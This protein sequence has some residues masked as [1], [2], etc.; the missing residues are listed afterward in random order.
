[1]ESLD[2]DA[3]TL[4]APADR[5]EGGQAQPGH[6]LRR[7]GDRH[8]DGG[9]DDP[10]RGQLPFDRGR[11]YASLRPRLAARARQPGGDCHCGGS[12]LILK[13]AGSV[14]SEARI[15]PPLFPNLNHLEVFREKAISFRPRR[16]ALW[17]R[18]S[19]FRTC[20]RRCR[21]PPCPPWA[22]QRPPSRFPRRTARR[23]RSKS[24]RGKWVVLYFYPKDMTSG[25]TIEA[26][27]FQDEPAPVRGQECGDSGRERGHR[28]QPQAVL[29]QGRAD[30]P[31]A[32]DP[33][34]K[35][36]SA[37]GS[38]GGYNGMTIANRNTFLIDPQGQDRQ[39]VDQGE[40]GD[41]ASDVLAV[42]PDKGNSIK[43][44]Q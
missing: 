8:G 7:A 38:L 44:A 40:P 24:F 35:V 6:A 27:N 21:R 1:M 15:P 41:R 39:G 9:D 19:L 28:R 17:P 16:S 3:S 23:F 5:G 29:H 36:V 18:L 37:Y 12:A 30:L 42:L 26:H 11:A 22:R 34:H 13:G 25:C 20:G 33:D 32:A 4:R 14:F 10:R 43:E 2:G 31:S